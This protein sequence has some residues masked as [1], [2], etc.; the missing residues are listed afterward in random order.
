MP[1]TAVVRDVLLGRT[2]TVVPHRLLRD[3]GTTLLLAHW[4]GIVSLMPDYWVAGMRT[5]DDRIRLRTLPDVAAGRWTLEPHTWHTTSRLSWFGVDDRFSV[6]RFFGSDGRPLSWYV[7]FERPWT[8]TPGGI[9]TCDLWVDLVAAPDLSAWSWKDEDEYAQARRL[10]LVNLEEHAAI[11][12]A[13]ERAVALIESRGGPFAE[14]W[15]S[16]QPDPAWPLPAIPQ[17]TRPLSS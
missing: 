2:R 11:D 6:H 17:G 15:P 16:W 4:P 10:G 14:A 12:Q 9:T 1:A 8:R 3:T 7:N 5:G 13:R